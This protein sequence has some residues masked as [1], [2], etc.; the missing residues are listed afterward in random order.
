MPQHSHETPSKP[1]HCRELGPPAHRWTMSPSTG[2][3]EASLQRRIRYTESYGHD[4]AAD[5]PSTRSSSS[6]HSSSRQ[7]HVTENL[8]QSCHEHQSKAEHDSSG[9]SE[10]WL[11]TSACGHGSANDEHHDCHIKTPVYLPSC[12]GVGTQA[13][14]QALGNRFVFDRLEP[15]GDLDPEVYTPVFLHD[16]LMLPGS[17]AQLIG[18][19]RNR[20]APFGILTRRDPLIYFPAQSL[21]HCPPSYSSHPFRL[22]VPCRQHYSRGTHH[23]LY[24]WHR[25]RARDHSPRLRQRVPPAD[26]RPL[27]R[28]MSSHSNAN[29]NRGPC[30][31]AES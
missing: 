3:R 27:P 30:A 16:A 18:K 29:S 4:N 25:C 5:S 19:V 24:L 12:S 8:T 21:G 14:F 11:A 31:C 10:A 7:S 1:L 28:H 9:V 17:L 2:S 6:S 22:P 15:G 23:P 13:Y 20:T 26:Q